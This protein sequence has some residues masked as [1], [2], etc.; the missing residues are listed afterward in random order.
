MR[1]IYV[2]I[3]TLLIASN[4]FSQTENIHFRRISP[5]GG[6]NFKAMH[7][8][9]QDKFGYIWFG[10]SYG[11]LR[12]DSKNII[13]FKYTPYDKNGLPDNNVTSIAIDKENNIWTSTNKGLSL[14]NRKNLKFEQIHYTY[15]N[16]SKNVNKIYSIQ[17][18]ENDT[19]WIA[20]KTY[21]G[22]FDKKNKK[23]IRI[24]KDK[25]LNP[26]LLYQDKYN[27]LWLGTNKGSVYLINKNSKELTNIIKDAG[28]TVQT[29]YCDKNHIW[30]GSKYNGAS[31]YDLKGN[32]IK[33][34]K[35]KNNSGIETGIDNVR[36]IIKDS[37]NNLWIGSYSGLYINKGNE[38]I[39]I[40]TIEE[41]IPHKSIFDILED[42][43]EGIW[44]GTWSGGVAYMKYSDNNFINYRNLKRP[45]DISD[46]MISSFTQSQDGT[47]YV[48]TELWGLNKF[49]IKTSKF[50]KIKVRETNKILNI[51]ALE[52]D[53]QGGLWIGSAFNGVYYKPYN[54]IKF[55]HFPSG[56]EDGKH[57]SRSE[58]Y[59]LCKSDS[60]MWIGTNKGGL[61]FYHF[62]TKKITFEF[63]T[64]TL[65]LLRNNNIK[66]IS[67][68]NNNNIWICTKECLYK[69]NLLSN[70]SIIFSPTSPEPFKTKC[71]TF[72]FAE[73][74]SDGNIWIGSSNNGIYIYY[75]KGNIIKH[76]EMNNLLDNKDVYGILEDDNKNIWIT[77]NY[78][79]YLY[80]YKDKSI[81]K[82]TDADGIQGNIFN[83]N[84]I[85]KD[86]NGI[87]YFGGTNG[88]TVFKS[89][90]VNTN[91]RKPNI[92][93]PEIEVSGKKIIVEQTDINK[94][95]PVYL[96][97][98]EN[99][100][101]IHFTADNYLLSKKNKFKYKLTNYTKNWISCNQ[102]ISATFINV[103]AGHYIFEV[104]ACNNDGVWNNKPAKIS[105]T[106]NQY[107]YKTTL[108][109]IIYLLIILTTIFII[110]R[111]YKEKLKL[112]EKL[113]DEKKDHEQKEKLQEMELKFFTNISHEFRTSLM[114]IKGPVKQLLNDNN[115]NEIQINKLNIIKRN[116][117]RLL[118]LI[119]QTL[120]FRKWQNSL[121]K[122]TISKIDIV[123]FIKEITQNFSEETNSKNIKLSFNSN[124]DSII[125]EAD[126][127]KLDK[128]LYNLISN[129]FKYTPSNGTIKITINENSHEGKS[130]FENKLIYGKTEN[131]EIVEIRI[132]DNGCGINKT[133]LPKIFERFQQGETI[134]PG[135][136]SSGIGLNICKELILKHRGSITIESTENIGTLISIKLPKRQKNIELTNIKED[137]NKTIIISKNQ[138]KQTSKKEK[139]PNIKILIIEDNNDLRSYLI[140]LIKD[141]YSVL[142]AIDGKQGLD[143]IK[144][145]NI[146]LII[147]DIMMPGI[148]GYEFCKIIKSQI[149]TSFIPVILLSALSSSENISTGFDIGA[150]A[151][152]PKPFDDNV[153]LSRI[154]NI[155]KKRKEIQQNFTKKLIKEES[156]NLGS[157]DNYFLTKINSI[158]EKNIKNQ[159]F[160]IDILSSEM[161]F[162]RSQLYRKLK[163]IS[164]QSPTEY[165]N[166]IRIKK[167]TELIDL[168][169]YTLDEVA[170]MTGFNSHSYFTKC[171]KRIYGKN[172]KEYMKNL[173][174]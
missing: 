37:H 107:W 84:A 30:V 117:Y 10:G 52:T 8:F 73:Q 63:Q 70:K 97:P 170:F 164:N 90:F 151:Y 118:Q 39:R 167:A 136:N 99:S 44:I 61:N 108:A 64:R 43:Q 100:I 114:L 12:Y 125:I 131:E 159:N 42:N 86:R 158:I 83:P 110:L 148:N 4:S 102:N 1:I 124:K 27:R 115:L 77:T 137:E 106:I 141:Y 59:A 20:D 13:H 165:I 173:K 74:L 40:D 78:G 116:S 14:L 24:T 171:F 23:L 149:E 11:I 147:S 92:F 129:A 91:K 93:I 113:S 51:K 134:K 82:F 174:K 162:S 138:E 89:K 15:E 96:K 139:N 57:V 60:G 87:L 130:I 153:L 72:Y 112:K 140:D 31:L 168:Q 103:P 2:F 45:G 49:D 75:P 29:I 34:Y 65:S 35:I 79:L 3:I 142:F 7:S 152:I 55:I 133:D 53:K 155:L 81:R 38:I 122:L 32:F 128:I 119:N 26:R 104:L 58:V 22:F 123:S 98:D 28:S 62:K 19:I 80:N 16:G 76:L 54:S 6:Y 41:G 5:Q 156:I 166:I 69:Y 126:N 154:R 71:E 157:M 169:K 101:T 94:F 88:I 161:G 109:K 50:S 146:D 172:P 68:D 47:I 120:N 17:F 143:I 21:V 132:Q 127:E 33:R 145:E 121:E 111:F 9:V 144:S 18:D 25:H 160:T 105:I 150:D 67:K 95:S 66:K 56:E 85:F 135:E 46:N 36:K 48:G 163:Q